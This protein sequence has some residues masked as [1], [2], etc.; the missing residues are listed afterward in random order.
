MAKVDMT[1]K[2]M[3]QRKPFIDVLDTCTKGEE[4]TCRKKKNFIDIHPNT[5]GYS[6]VFT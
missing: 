5:V 6:H 2:T 1:T 3:V 4:C